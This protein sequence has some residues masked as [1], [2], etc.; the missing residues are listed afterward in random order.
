MPLKILPVNAICKYFR[1]V[2]LL[3]LKFLIQTAKHLLH[4]TIHNCLFFL[5]HIEF[6]LYRPFA[7]IHGFSLL[8]VLI[9]G[10]GHFPTSKNPRRSRKGTAGILRKGYPFPMLAALL[11]F[12][13]KLH[14][15]IDVLP[16]RI[17]QKDGSLIG[18][19]CF[20]GIE[21]FHGCLAVL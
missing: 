1:K 20:R 14:P 21:L 7:S 10:L 8:S 17:S 9:E 4:H 13:R 19:A 15:V 18:L 16:A 11:S 2:I 3:L 12:L 6:D 5:C